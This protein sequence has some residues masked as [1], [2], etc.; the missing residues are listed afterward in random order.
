MRYRVTMTNSRRKRIASSIYW[1]RKH[2][3]QEY[4]DETNKNF[5]GSNARVVQDSEKVRRM[6]P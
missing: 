1:E 3:A 2:W 6:I 5:P 4:A